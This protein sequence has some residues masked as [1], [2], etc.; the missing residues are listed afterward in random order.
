M[1]YQASANGTGR[2][3][4]HFGSHWA[5]R[6]QVSRELPKESGRHHRRYLEVR[7]DWQV[8]TGKA[9]AAAALESR[10]GAFRQGNCLAPNGPGRW[11]SAVRV[12]VAPGKRRNDKCP[13]S[14]DPAAWR[15]AIYAAQYGRD[16]PARTRDIAVTTAAT[17]GQLTYE[18]TSTIVTADEQPAACHDPTTH[19]R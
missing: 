17:L 8:A 4:R 7:L 1:V 5:E 2:R 10:A 12:I 6:P 15:R 18:Q 14:A 13:N 9:R 11:G 16:Q 19:V 3:S